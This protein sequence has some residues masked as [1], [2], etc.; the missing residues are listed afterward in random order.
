[1]RRRVSGQNGA[2]ASQRAMAKPFNGE[3]LALAREARRLSQ[4]ELSRLDGRVP[5]AAISKIEN[6]R[7][8]PERSIAE[9][10][11]SVLKYRPSFFYHSG[12]RRMP[13]VS[14]HR[15][16]QKLGARDLA[17]IHAQS[18]IYRINLSKLLAAIELEAR[19]PAPPAIDPDQHGGNVR[20]IADTVRQRWGIPRGQISDLTRL[21]EDS[22]I[23]VVPFDF[24]TPLIDGFSQHAGDGL[25]PIIFINA[26][27]PKDRYR[28]SLAH[29]LAHIIMHHTPNPEQ[30][31]Q[32]NLFASEFLMPRRDIEPHLYNLSIQKFMDLKLHWGVSMQAIMHKAWETGRI[33]DRMYKYYNIELARRGFRA[34]EPIALSNFNEAPS[35][36]REIINEYLTTLEYTAD[37]LAELCGI[38]PD[39]FRSLYPVP[40]Q[41]PQLRIVV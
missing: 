27:Q 30:E 18:E 33:S 5:Q 24:G 1:M 34:R 4:Q 16:R 41:R 12:F 19:L 36:L 10:F 14:F 2:L 40:T 25:P 26:A 29:E 21:I 13:P 11:A 28:F 37:D 32:A 15:K 39:E 38:L 23:I 6:G 8:Q 7:I 22:G 17:A 3:M 35:V 20:I 9:R 31:I